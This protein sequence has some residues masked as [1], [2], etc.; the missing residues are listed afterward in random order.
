M[1]QDA[2]GRELRYP[3]IVADLLVLLEY[4]E[5]Y[6]MSNMERVVFRQ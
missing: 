5:R 2:M 1:E 3:G 4:L 6:R